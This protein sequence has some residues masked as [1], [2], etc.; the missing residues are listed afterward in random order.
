MSMN[1]DAIAERIRALRGYPIGTMKGFLEY[2]S[3][4]GVKTR[5]A[6]KLSPA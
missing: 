1:I 6:Q 2:A 3:L 4:G 5:S